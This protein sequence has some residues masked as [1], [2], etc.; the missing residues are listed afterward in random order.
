MSKKAN[1]TMIGIFVVGAMVLVI[2]GLLMFGKGEFFS[3]KR[4]FVL[5]FDES[6]HGLDIGAPVIFRGV[7][8][9]AVSDVKMNL[10]RKKLTFWI[11]VLIEIEPK[12][13]TYID[14]VAIAE[15]IHIDQLVKLGLRA[16][17]QTQSVVTGKLFVALDLH[18]EKTARLTGYDSRYPEIPT[19]PTALKEVT[20]TATK[21][22][23]EIRKIPVKEIAEKVSSILD[24]VNKLVDSSEI[25]D[26]IKAFKQAT[27]NIEQLVSNIDRRVES[28][29][30]SVTDT[31]KDTRKLVKNVDSQVE[32]VAS[33]VTDTLKDTR[34]LVNNV[35]SKVEP[36]TSRME[37]SVDELSA[38]LKQAKKSLAAL[39][40]TVDEDSSLQYNLT[41]TL[42]QIGDAARSLRHLSDYLERHPEALLKGK[43]GTGGK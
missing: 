16:Q 31:L 33:S 3:E 40:S 5:Y 23:E 13:I 7:K 21:I 2:I 20:D 32:S 1:P 14:E 26:S 42:E 17:L 41:D 25:S 27:K 22:I 37:N 9:G 11:P 12:R 6:I 39:E 34:Q 38:A 28:V 24:S 43:K 30:S 18:P 4:T 35:D 36:L 19:I 15:P 10:D 29:A 8:I